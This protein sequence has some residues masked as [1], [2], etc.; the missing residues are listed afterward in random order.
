ML[1]RIG[2]SAT[3]RPLEVVAGYLGGNLV[4]RTVDPTTAPATV[5][6]DPVERPVRIVDA[7]VRKELD[8]QVVVPVEDMGTP[9]GP[10]AAT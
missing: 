8:L 3:Q 5:R 10:A 2:L 9:S 4:E 6:P 1:Q 7:G